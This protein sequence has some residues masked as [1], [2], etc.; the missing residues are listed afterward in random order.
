MALEIKFDYAITSDRTKLVITDTTGVYDVNNTTGWGA[1]NT[2]R[3]AVGLYAYVTYQPFN[4][5]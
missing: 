1:P 5:S 3:S 4:T 2:E